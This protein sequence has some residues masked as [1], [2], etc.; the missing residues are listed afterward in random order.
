MRIRRLSPQL[1]SN[2]AAG[3]VVERPASVVKELLENSLDAGADHLHI[4]VE[5]G[6]VKRICVRDNGSGIEK[7]D[8]ELALC[9]HT[10]SKVISVEDLENVSTLG[11]RGEALASIAAVSHFELISRTNTQQAAWKLSVNYLKE[12]NAPVPAAHPVGTTAVVRDLF[13][14]I[15]ARRKFLRTERTEFSRLEKVAKQIA[16]S[17]FDV[18]IHMYHNRRPVFLLGRTSNQKEQ[19]RRLGE[20]C[21]QVFAENALFVER[22]VDAMRLWG[23]FGFPSCSRSRPDLQ[24]CFVNHRMVRDQLITHAVRQAYQDVLYHGRHPAFIFYLTIDPT[25]IDVNAHPTKQEIRWREPRLVHEVIYRTLQESFVQIRPMAPASDLPVTYHSQKKPF[26]AL[27]DD[28]LTLFPS[29]SDRVDDGVRE[30]PWSF[31]QVD[32]PIFETN[33]PSQS[34]PINADTE[35]L[36]GYAV[37]QFKGIYILAENAAGLVIVDIYAAHERI[38]YERLKNNLENQRI[39]SKPLSVPVTVLLNPTEMD[40]LDQFAPMLI[41]FGFDVVSMGP[42]MAI[43]RKIPALLAGVDVKPLLRHVLVDLAEHEVSTQIQDVIHQTLAKAACLGSVRAN[44]ELTIDEMNAL[45]RTVEHTERSGQCHYGRPAW[46]QI[47]LTELDK[48][49]RRGR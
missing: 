1:I 41:E 38:T 29:P 15:P 17:R 46:T 20:V 19:E 36:L 14:N 49:F 3:E 18:E 7:D 22:E 33:N 11:F 37:A 48:L 16:L 13:F 42:E 23:W 10:T 35:P 45:L 47:N 27:Q 6:G 5:N 4:E 31:K 43:V 9:R 44:C 40:L 8:L 24:Y 28:S 34:T 21:G 39:C 12:A 2:I 25:Q 32:K 26:I 30:N